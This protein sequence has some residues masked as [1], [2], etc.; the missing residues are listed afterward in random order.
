MKH[1]D[2]RVTISDTTQ[3]LSAWACCFKLVSHWPSEACLAHHRANC[4][5]P[6]PVAWFYYSVSHILLGEKTNKQ[7]NPK[8]KNNQTNQPSNQT[9]KKKHKI[10]GR[11]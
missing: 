1:K 6:A 4:K 9:N 8:T 5:A 2:F 10:N 7:T 11:S 3:S